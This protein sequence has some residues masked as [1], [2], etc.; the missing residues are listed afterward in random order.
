MFWISI[1]API[2]MTYI[3]LMLGA[4]SNGSL[5]YQEITAKKGTIVP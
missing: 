2:S 1:I 4:R 5:I 3:L